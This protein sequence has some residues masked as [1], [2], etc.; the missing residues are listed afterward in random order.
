MTF[1]VSIK[2]S[3]SRGLIRICILVRR[4][5]MRYHATLRDTTPP[6]GLFYEGHDCAI[7]VATYAI[8]PIFEW[9]VTREI[10]NTK[11]FQSKNTPKAAVH[12]CAGSRGSYASSRMEINAQVA[13]A[14]ECAGSSGPCTSRR[15]ERNAPEAAV[16]VPLGDWKGMRRKQLSMYL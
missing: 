9:R 13:A 5:L 8:R 7:T 2:P 10:N 4:I 11:Q 15:L 16:H 6:C 1:V 3:H 12:E 14:H